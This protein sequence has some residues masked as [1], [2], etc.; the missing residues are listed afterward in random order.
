MARG[1]GE[2]ATIVADPTFGPDGS[3]GWAISVGWGGASQEE[4]LTYCG[5][6]SSLE[7]IPEGWQG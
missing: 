3:G 4:A 2:V 1:G 7:G 5:R 6:Y